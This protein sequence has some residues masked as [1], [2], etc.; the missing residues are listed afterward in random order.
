MWEFITKPKNAADG[1]RFMIGVANFIEEPTI[2][3][4]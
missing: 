4:S 2:G 3:G 1:S